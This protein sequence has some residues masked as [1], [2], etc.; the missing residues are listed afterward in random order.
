MTQRKR[1]QTKAPRRSKFDKPGLEQKVCVACG[2]MTPHESKKIDTTVQA[3][4]VVGVFAMITGLTGMGGAI[5]ALIFSIPA[6]WALGKIKTYRCHLCGRKYSKEK[7][8][9]LI[10]ERNRKI[11]KE[12]WEKEK[13]SR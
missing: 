6:F 2:E 8:N 3:A 7:A 4:I 5:P 12:Q 9:R 11:R 1:I 13:Q 10:Q